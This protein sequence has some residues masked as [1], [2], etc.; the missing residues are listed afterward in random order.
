MSKTISIVLVILFIVVAGLAYLN[1]NRLEQIQVD[2]LEKESMLKDS[3]Q[4][5]EEQGSVIVQLEEKIK[6]TTETTETATIEEL[7]SSQE[8]AIQE[9]LTDYQEE[10]KEMHEKLEKAIQ[11][12]TIESQTISQLK[13]EKL[14]LEILF[15]KKEAEWKSKEEMN[16]KNIASLQQHINAYE[17]DISKVNE[18]MSELEKY[19]NMEILKRET[20]ESEILEY[21]EKITKLHERLNLEQDDENYVQEISHLQV[22]KKQLEE[23]IDQKNKLLEEIKNEYQLLKSELTEYEKKMAGLQREFIVAE[24]EKIVL[25]EIQN[26]LEQLKQEKNKLEEILYEKEVQW[27]AKEEKS[28]EAITHLQEEVKEYEMNLKSLGDQILVIKQDMTEKANLKDKLSKE[29]NLFSIEINKSKD[30][31]ARFQGIEESSRDTINQLV[32]NKELLERQLE[33]KGLEIQQHDYDE[34]IKQ[35]DVYRNQLKEVEKEIALARQ[36]EEY[37][38][39]GQLSQLQQDLKSLEKMLAEKKE[40]WDK[41]NQENKKLISYLNDQLEKYQK[42]IEIVKIDS[43]LLKEEMLVQ[44]ELQQERMARIKDREEQISELTK[45]IEDYA[46]KMEDYENMVSQLR[47]KLEEQK[48]LSYQEQKELIDNLISLVAERD[49]I[50]DNIDKYHNQINQLQSE[51]SG[52]QS[53]IASLEEKDSQYY[54]IKRGDSLWKIAKDRYKEGIAWTKI[55]RANQDLIENPDLI[56]PYQQII[57]PD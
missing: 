10:L 23:D 42:E 12:S 37:L 33:E 47:E 9:K 11:Q 14:E 48:D 13:Q 30:E 15:Q 28:K 38:L 44:A 57:I 54:E 19:L 39:E 5:I 16:E 34:M 56:Y 52:L 4:L 49:I 7:I 17:Q 3:S 18:K 40:E 36:R 2:L 45:R 6:K 27:L 32:I 29:L 46:E 35:L 41:E 51:I 53:K 24:E 31:I 8:K 22:T 1:Y 21:E 55:F 25:K 26:N 20:M 43:S 50:Q